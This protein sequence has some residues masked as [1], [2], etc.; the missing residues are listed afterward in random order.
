MPSSFIFGCLKLKL[1]FCGIPL[2]KSIVNGDIV[3]DKLRQRY[4]SFFPS[5][6][7]ESSTV[8][9]A[10]GQSPWVLRFSRPLNYLELCKL[11]IV[12]YLSKKISKKNMKIIV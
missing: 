8:K 5:K 11:Q 6:Y 10:D 4:K 9:I 7:V 1:S 12:S 3:L 2:P